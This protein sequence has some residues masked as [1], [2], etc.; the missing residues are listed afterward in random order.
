[1]PD[2][3]NKLK[4]VDWCE[5]FAFTRIF[6]SFSLAMNISSMALSLAAIILMCLTGWVMD[7]AFDWAG[8][9]VMVGEIQQY[10]S[11]KGPQF[12]LAKRTLLNS[13][14]ARVA[15]LQ[16]DV[17]RE[18]YDMSRFRSALSKAVSRKGREG[19]GGHFLAAFTKAADAAGKKARKDFKVPAREKLEED[20]QEDWGEVLSTAIKTSTERVM[21]IE[22]LIDVAFSEARKHIDEDPELATSKKRRI[23]AY[24]SLREDRIS[25]LKALTQVKMDFAAKVREIQGEMISSSFIDY[26]GD[27]LKKGV[28]ALLSGNIATGLTEYRDKT[29]LTGEAG[30]IVQMLRA[31][32]G[33]KWLF[34]EHPLYAAIA[35]L[36][37][38]AIWALLG[39]AVYRIAALQ[40]AR[41]E[42][43]S[44]MQ[45]LRFSRSK[46]LSFFAA[47]LMPL[48][49]IL[50]AGV[51][52]MAGGLLVNVPFVGPI[53]VGALF[54]LALLLG[55]MIAFLLVGLV[56]GA[57]LMYPTIAVE[58]SDCFD[59]MSRSYSYVMAKPWQGGL[60][61]VVALV[62]GSIC[63]LFVRVFA[64]LALSAT[65][66]FVRG[67][68]FVG[69]EALPGVVSAD[70]MDVL[71]TAPTFGV[72]HAWNWQAMG[73]GEAI[74]AVCIAVW[75]YVIIGLVAAFALNYFAGSMTISYYLLRR[76]VD[77]IDFDEVYMD[78]EEKPAQEV[79]GPETPQQGAA[80]DAA[81]PPAQDRDA[82]EETPDQAPD[83]PG[84]EKQQEGE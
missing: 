44:L 40:A 8:E 49:I 62:H 26:E 64:F 33:V 77:S 24:A 42:K 60:Y 83:E 66:F 28:I 17:L 78:T 12:V 67:A 11:V 21:R 57:A 30:F 72:L 70:K 15:A 14:P 56:S 20:A 51:V 45:A 84:D 35:T 54:I 23:D 69:G 10:T 55:L 27:C 79:A 22:A 18:K 68:V 75:V 74:G 59:A 43:I 50:G 6:K 81:E 3:R 82:P 61:G 52:L 63:Y 29:P 9:S 39:G 48:G 32:D 16:R 41:E 7:L 2:E 80:A 36:L 53:I 47:P 71:W 65:H 37:C 58:G 25:A 76:K 73:T 13:R 34:C 38:M 46:F 4:N 19:E 5:V 1:M 31:V